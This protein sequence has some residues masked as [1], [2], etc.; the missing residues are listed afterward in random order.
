[1]KQG[2]VSLVIWD[3]RNAQTLFA[4]ESNH[5]HT[6]E[7]IDDYRLLVTLWPARDDP[8]CLVLMEL[9]EGTGGTP[10]QTSF[11]LSPYFRGSGHLFPHLERGAYKPSPSESVA[12]FHQDPAQRIVVLSMTYADCYLVFQAEALL[13]LAEDRKGSEI[14]W[15]D[16]KSIV[17]IPHIRDPDPVDV[18]VS[19][20]QLLCITSESTLQEIEIEVY[21]FSIRGRK[22]YMSK[23]IN[24]D[25]D[26]VRYL[27]STGIRAR[28]PW[29]VDELLDSTSGHDS[30][31]FFRMPHGFTQDGT[32]EGK[33]ILHIWRF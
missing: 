10:T 17:I 30:I 18:W 28:H 14:E 20:S 3:W 26:G 4:R 7:F 32:G 22:D 23:R 5:Y 11:R 8:P 33:G 31:L 29:D 13:R 16:W 27:T 6:A 19:G 24:R 21:D 12:P 2:G 15:D 9:G 25:L 1:M